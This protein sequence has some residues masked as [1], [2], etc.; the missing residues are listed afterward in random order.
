MASQEHKETRSGAGSAHATRRPAEPP[1]VRS[2]QAPRKPSRGD[3][4]DLDLN[5][6]QGREQAGYRPA[7]IISVDL[8]N[9]GSAELV[10][11]IPITRV[12]KGIR[13]HVPVTPPEGG[14]SDVSYI[15]CE[16]VR[17]LSRNRLVRY[18]GRV[19]HHTMAEVEDRLRI[20]MGL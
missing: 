17:S 13:W 20:L 1:R 10:V 2:A 11:A 8:F 18:R 9:H 19:S 14:L 15:K 12:E 4:W 5:P 6:V 7:L 16:D 3:V